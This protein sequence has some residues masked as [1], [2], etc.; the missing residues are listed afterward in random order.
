MN[1]AARRPITDINQVWTSDTTYFR[2]GERHYYI[3]F[4]MDVYSR[5]ILGFAASKDLG[6]EA[7]CR[8]LRMALET[9]QGHDL[10][11]L[12][13]HSDRGSQYGSDK[14]I[15]ILKAKE[16]GVSMCDSVYEN[17]HV[18]RVNGIT[19][20]EYLSQWPIKDFDALKRRLSQ[21]VKIYNECRPHW[22]LGVAPP[23][24]YEEKL[25]TIAQ[26]DRDVMTLYMDKKTY[27]LQQ[28]FFE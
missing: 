20:N 24:K 11:G 4:V 19:K 9:R 12:I 1:L 3:T 10:K 2:I 14:Y 16:I 13:H 17:T 26:K 15:S 28:S 8:A 22:S 27:V 23:A 21:A 18:E 7:N 6:A 5:R 25:K